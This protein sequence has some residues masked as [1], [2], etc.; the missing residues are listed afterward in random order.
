MHVG[1]SLKEDIWINCNSFKFISAKSKRHKINY[2]GRAGHVY[3]RRMTVSAANVYRRVYFLS[4]L[5]INFC[6]F[7]SSTWE[8]EI[9]V[10]VKWGFPWGRDTIPIWSSA[11]KPFEV[12]SLLKI[13]GPWF[14][15]RC[16]VWA[17]IQ[18]IR[19]WWTTFVETTKYGIRIRQGSVASTE[20]KGL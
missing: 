9:L 17:Q 12:A 20:G 10:S 2:A 18:E 1:I 8:L 14:R 16:F 4:F 5:Q 15:L 19:W 13:L 7:S 3:R 6:Q 11:R